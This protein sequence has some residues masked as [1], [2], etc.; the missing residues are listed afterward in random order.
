MGEALL[1]RCK[2]NQASFIRANLAYADLSYARMTTADFSQADL[3][4]ARIHCMEDSKVN[5]KDAVR[6][7]MRRTDPDLAR[8]EVWQP[9]RPSET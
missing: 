2:A 6:Q 5:Y 4:G 3:T 8:A 9:P 1:T 7:R